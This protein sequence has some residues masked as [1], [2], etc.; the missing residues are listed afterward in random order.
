MFELSYHL[1]TVVDS[2]TEEN[3]PIQSDKS[4]TRIGTYNRFPE[5]KANK[6][7]KQEKDHPLSGDLLFTWKR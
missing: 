6:S 1:Q 5:L 7:T 3:T 2:S 4:I